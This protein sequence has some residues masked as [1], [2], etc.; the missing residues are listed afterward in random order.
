MGA[1]LLAT[2]EA[3]LDGLD[4][5]HER[6]TAAGLTDAVRGAVTEP[7]VGAPLPWEG[8]SLDGTGVNCQPTPAELRD[9][10]TGV[11]AAGAAVAEY[12]SLVVQSRPGGDE[13]ASV[14]PP[15]HV[16]VLREGDLVPDVPAAVAWLADEFE[17]GRRSAV[18]ATGPSSTADM[19]ELVR[20]VHG[21]QAVHVVTV[22]DR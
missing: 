5:T 12:G 10:Q 11:T 7:A 22:T 3:S 13:P 20:G 16:A 15:R 19:G 2:F 4:V 14:Y 8:L 1:E 6:T 17:A 9:A 21:P 18:L